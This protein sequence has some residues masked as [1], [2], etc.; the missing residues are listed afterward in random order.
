MG[1]SYSGGQTLVEKFL[2][3]QTKVLVIAVS[4]SCVLALQWP[5][6]G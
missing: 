4:S 3:K 5:F 1:F 2:K 6:L